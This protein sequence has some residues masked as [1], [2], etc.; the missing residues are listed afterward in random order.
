MI[1]SLGVRENLREQSDRQNLHAEQG[2]EN[3]EEHRVNVK[4]DPANP[5]RSRQQPNH[6]RQSHGDER[7][8]G[9]EKQPIGSEEQHEPQVAPAVAKTAQ[10]WGP[11]ALVG[12]K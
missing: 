2:K 8:A 10:V 5:M 9:D 7:S 3:P 12:P 6:E 1:E 4:T 11:S